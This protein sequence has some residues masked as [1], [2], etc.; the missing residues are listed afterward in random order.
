MQDSILLTAGYLSIPAVVCVVEQKLVQG[1]PVAIYVIGENLY[2]YLF[3]INREEWGA[4]AEITL[5]PDHEYRSGENVLAKFFRLRN[6]LQSTYQ[7]Y[8]APRPPGDVYIF[9]RNYITDYL[10]Y[11]NR[12]LQQGHTFWL[13]DVNSAEANGVPVQWR[14]L[15]WMQKF[16]LIYWK[17]LVGTGIEIVCL[18]DALIPHLS[19]EYVAKHVQTIAYPRQIARS[20]VNALYKKIVSQTV[21]QFDLIYFDQMVDAYLTEE[22]SMFFA[23]LSEVLKRCMDCRYAVKRHPQ[24]PVSNIT[25]SSTFMLPDYIPGEAYLN[26]KTKFFVTCF[27]ATLFGEGTGNG[28]RIF[29]IDMLPFRDESQRNKLKSVIQ[30]GV[31]SYSN[32]F[33]PTNFEELESCLMGATADVC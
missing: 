21:S 32:I 12:F 27:S 17:M 6:R 18:A 1:N 4:R 30:T 2:K 29:L 26:D 9:A 11:L 19:D 31:G 16:Y 23:R 5:L 25:V 7:N 13:M 15:P 33:F 24:S 3:I 10:Y 22:K 28:L 8:F 14:K 20:R